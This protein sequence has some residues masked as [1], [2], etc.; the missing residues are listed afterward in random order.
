V[1]LVLTETFARCVWKQIKYCYDYRQ[2]QN[3]IPSGQEGNGKKA[4]G[5]ARWVGDMLCGVNVGMYNTSPHDVMLESGTSLRVHGIS[6][7]SEIVNVS[8]ISN[9]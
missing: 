8:G 9:M 3:I 2:H 5:F 4:G 6:D 1:P 7:N